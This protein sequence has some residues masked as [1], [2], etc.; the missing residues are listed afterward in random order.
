MVQS[1]LW[2]RAHVQFDIS[3]TCQTHEWHKNVKTKEPRD[4]KTIK[5]NASTSEQN[6]EKIVRFEVN[7]T[8]FP[9]KKLVSDF[10]LM[11]KSRALPVDM[12]TKVDHVIT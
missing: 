12:Q 1:L 10:L 7:S 9:F 5:L 4:H 8:F 2:N 3:R 6:Q 11:I